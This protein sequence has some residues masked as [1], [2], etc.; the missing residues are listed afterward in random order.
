MP[1]SIPPSDAFAPAYNVALHAVRDLTLAPDERAR[2][3]DLFVQVL[4]IWPKRWNESIE[5]ETAEL[6]L[7]CVHEA[8][9]AEELVGLLQAHPSPATDRILLTLMRRAYEGG[10][11]RTLLVVMDLTTH[12]L[13]THVEIE[14]RWI[15]AAILVGVGYRRAGGE[16]RGED[17]VGGMVAGVGYHWSWARRLARWPQTAPSDVM[18]V[19]QGV[20][21]SR[22]QAKLPRRRGAEPQAVEEEI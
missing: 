10:H 5:R 12:L 15:E 16:E 2:V 6:A 17:A 1:T 20:G 9:T 13:A 8:K 21:Q 11:L 22:L 19:Q 3:I 14:D 18:I 7:L 4:L